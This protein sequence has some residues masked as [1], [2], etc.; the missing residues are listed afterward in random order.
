[1]NIG[2]TDISTYG[3]KQYR[4]TFEQSSLSNDTEWLKGSPLPIWDSNYRKSK[5]VKFELL[6]YG[7]S[8]EA[9]RN[10]ISNVIALCLNP[11]EIEPEGYDRKFKGVLSSS[12]VDE[13]S[14][15]ARKRY[16]H[17]SLTF[18]CY[19][20]G[21]QETTTSSGETSVTV[22]N[23]G[24]VVSPCILQITPTIGI[25]SL[26]ISGVCRNS[27]SGAD[28]PITVEELTTG[29][30]IIFDGVS[31]LVTENNVIREVDMWAL[32]TLTPGSNT[33]TFSSNRINASVA[34][35][36]LYI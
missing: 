15:T 1:M 27:F 5:R 35:L 3:A 6:V 28:L 30:T 10:N 7:S 29:N 36:P 18:D 13:G 16:Q 11:V 21:D 4:I 17:L 19:E 26:T 2:G 23:P 25:S 34:V 24:N 12:S 20:H 33:I 14:D 8:R 31:G 9:I 32:P 22:N